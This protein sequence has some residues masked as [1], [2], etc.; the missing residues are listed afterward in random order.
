MGTNQARR[1]LQ[2][3]QNTRNAT[4]MALQPVSISSHPLQKLLGTGY[5]T[6]L[7]KRTVM[8]LTMPSHIQR[9]VEYRNRPEKLVS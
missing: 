6:Q 2:S 5:E 4:L 8:R 9:D 1:A 7:V 3:L